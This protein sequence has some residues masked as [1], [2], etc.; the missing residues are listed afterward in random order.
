MTVAEALTRG[1]GFCCQ[2]RVTSDSAW[3]WMTKSWAAQGPSCLHLSLGAWRTMLSGQPTQVASSTLHRARSLG[4]LSRCSDSQQVVGNQFCG[5]AERWQRVPQT[6]GDPYPPVLPQL[7]TWAR[8]AT[9]SACV[10]LLGPLSL[11]PRP[12][13][14]SLYH[15]P[16]MLENECPWE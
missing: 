5:F 3:M 15:K 4:F 8:P 9:T 11:P 13:F 14:T 2:T 10:P 7:C 16:R 1:S 12:Y 6:Q